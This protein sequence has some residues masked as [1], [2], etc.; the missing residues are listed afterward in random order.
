[1]LM[2]SLE[3]ANILFKQITYPD[4]DH[5]LASMRPHLYHSLDRFFGACFGLESNKFFR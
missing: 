2:K 5:G 1:M 3:R 4:E